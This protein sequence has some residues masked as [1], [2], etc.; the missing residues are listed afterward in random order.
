MP[1]AGHFPSIWSLLTV[2]YLAASSRDLSCQKIGR[3]RTRRSTENSHRDRLYK[4]SY[5][6]VKAGASTGKLSYLD[7]NGRQPMSGKSSR[8][9]TSL[10]NEALKRGSHIKVVSHTIWTDLSPNIISTFFSFKIFVYGS[11]KNFRCTQFYLNISC[12]I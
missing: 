10:S 1:A 3:L 7:F 9:Y 6:T 8:R 4:G 2:A 11:F 12:T 5:A